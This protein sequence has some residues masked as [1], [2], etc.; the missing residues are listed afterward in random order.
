ME[1]EDGSEVSS[2]AA[3]EA[4]RRLIASEPKGKPYS[5]DQLV[6]LLEERDNLKLARRTV[7]KYREA[8]G[9]LASRIRKK[10]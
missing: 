10:L 6:K 3:K 5:D 7:T 4:I 1:Q 2:N 8:M 9:I